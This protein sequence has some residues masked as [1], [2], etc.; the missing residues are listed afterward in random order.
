MSSNTAL[1]DSIDDN[2]Q[3]KKMAKTKVPSDDK[4]GSASTV[5]EKTEK[6]DSKNISVPLLYKS[7][8]SLQT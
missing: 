3:E 2:N 1:M 4:S 5:T 7:G 8:S 6:L